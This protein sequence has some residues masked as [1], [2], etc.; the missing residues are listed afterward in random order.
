MGLSQG[1]SLEH[2]FGAMP[3][4]IL[5]GRAEIGIFNAKLVK[6]SFRSKY[7]VNI[8]PRNLNRFC[9]IYCIFLSFLI[10]AGD[11]EL[12]PGPRKNNTSYYFSFY[13][14]NLNTIAAHK[15][16]KLSLLEAYN[17]E[18]KFDMI[19]LSETFL[20]SS[21]P[22]NDERLNMKGYNLIRADNPSDGKKGYVGIYYKE[23][24]TVRPY[25]SMFVL[26]G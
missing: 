18:H 10:C 25:S 9:T 3:V 22:S 5:Q 24:L 8:C 14:W 6:Y 21:I 26:F 16:S 2:P 12:N 23:F 13:H 15:F 4:S 11:I 7:Q 19:C 20:D 17:V 1:H